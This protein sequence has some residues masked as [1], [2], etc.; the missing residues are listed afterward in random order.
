MAPRRIGSNIG[1]ARSAKP[2]NV[3]KPTNSAIN[4]VL[5]PGDRVVTKENWRTQKREKEKRKKV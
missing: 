4:A 2:F 1:K 5:G 3:D